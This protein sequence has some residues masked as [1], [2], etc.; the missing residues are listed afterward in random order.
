VYHIDEP[1][2]SALTQF[3]RRAIPPGSD[4]LDICSSWVS[5]YPREFPRAMGRICAAGISRDEL[6]LNDQVTDG[7]LRA[8]DLN[9]G[10]APRLPFPDAAFD[11]VTCVVSIDYLTRPVEV[12]RE[13][14]RVLR[15]GGQV[16]I[17]Q[18]NRCFPTKA[19]RLWL[20]LNDL[21]RLELIG[22]FLKYAGGYREPFEAWDITADGDGGDAAAGGRRGFDPMYVVRAVKMA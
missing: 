7:C 13:V 4:V 21:E 14:S 22:G 20:Q 18:S 1:A 10:D 16:L 17:S 5:H 6:A 3:Y 11:A 12:L 8:V 2:V 19:I 15:P 9:A